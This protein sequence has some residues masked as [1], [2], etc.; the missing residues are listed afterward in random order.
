[1]PKGAE[2][3]KP[4]IRKGS[5]PYTYIIGFKVAGDTTFYEYFQ[6]SATNTDMKMGYIKAYISDQPS[7]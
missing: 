7:K 2:D 1:M 5:T 6:V 3:I 4:I